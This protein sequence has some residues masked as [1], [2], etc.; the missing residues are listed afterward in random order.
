M[1]DF[2]QKGASYRRRIM[3]NYNNVKKQLLNRKHV[4]ERELD[5]TNE[6]GKEVSFTSNH[7]S[8]EL[9]YYDNHP[10]DSGTELFEREKNLGLQKMKYEELNDIIVALSKI[11]KG[12]YGIDERTGEKIPYE[13]LEAQPTASTTVKNSLNKS[14]H[15]DRPVEEAVIRDMEIEEDEGDEGAGF[16]EQN[17]YDLVAVYN[18]IDM[19]YDDSLNMDGYD[20]MDCVE[21]VE[22]IGATDIYGYRGDDHVQFLRNAHYDQWMNQEQVIEGED[23]K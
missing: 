5:F 11:E 3:F 21:M 10:A 19:T 20:D 16:N 12:T 8:S 9:S 13:R 15:D 1:D 14:I 17:A 18:Q 4:L 2:H 6:F 23:E 7:S 22:A